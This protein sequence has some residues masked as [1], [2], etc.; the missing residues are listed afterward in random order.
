MTMGIKVKLKLKTN[1][2]SAIKSGDCHLLK[3]I[4]AVFDLA[5]LTLGINF[6]C[7]ICYYSYSLKC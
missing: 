1:L 5:Q 3:M 4:F 7:C 2:Y 6:Y